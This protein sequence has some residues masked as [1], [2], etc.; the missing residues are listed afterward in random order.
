MKIYSDHWKFFGL[1]KYYFILKGQSTQKWKFCHYLLTPCCS[2]PVSLLFFLQNTWED[3]LKNVGNQNNLV[4]IEFYG[5]FSHH[6][7]S[8][9]LLLWHEDEKM[10]TELSFFRL[11]LPFR[12]L[13]CWMKTAP[14]H[15]NILILWTTKLKS[16]S[17]FFLVSFQKVGASCLWK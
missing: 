13:K 12:S 10:I 15:W 4:P 3:I 8:K 7:S 2:K 9:Y 17:F 1:L 5:I 6:H 16:V 14:Q 11:N